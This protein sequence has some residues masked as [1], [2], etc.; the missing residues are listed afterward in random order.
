MISF[1]RVCKCFADGTQ[2]LDNLEMEI[3]SGQLTV[4]AGPSGCGKT[5]TLRLINRLANASSG[6]VAIDGVDVHERDPTDLRRGIGYVMQHSGLFPHRTVRDNIATVPQ[7]LSWHKSRIEQ[8]VDELIEL[9]GLRTEIIDRYPHQLSGGQAQRVGVARAL[10]ADPP[11]LLMDEPFAAVDPIVR[12]RLQDEFLRL[13]DKVG[14]TI[15]FVT[16]DIDEAISLGDRIAIFQT[17]GQ[18]VQ[19]ASPSDV[20]AQPANSFVADFLGGE[21]ELRRLALMRVES[22]EAERGPEIAPDSSEERACETADAHGRDWVVIVADDGRLVGWVA[23]RDLKG[24]DAP[25]AD[26]IIQPFEQSVSAGDTL[27]TALGAI[28][29]SPLGVVPRVDTARGYTG[30]VTHA[31]LNSR[32]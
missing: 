11:I 32:L 22:V 24:G 17:G 31:S 7:L 26:A 25:I 8:R 9:V 16:H 4:L 1:D 27:R 2:A 28:V 12:K 15:V 10:A 13:Q 20:L 30:L 3:P 5:T 6:R 19:Y 14:K 23:R 18:L 29:N 21:R